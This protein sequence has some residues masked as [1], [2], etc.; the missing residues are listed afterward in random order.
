MTRLMHFESED[1][2]NPT[3]RGSRLR[4]SDPTKRRQ[5][6]GE[7]AKG[8]RLRLPLGDTPAETDATARVR[9]HISYLTRMAVEGVVSASLAR[10]A[11]AVW[12]VAQVSVGGSL[13]VPA[14]V[15]FS[16]GP[17]EYHWTVGSHQLS[18]EIPADGPCHWTYRNVKTCE[19][20]GVETEDDGPPP[21]LI[22]ALT[23]IAESSR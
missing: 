7:A 2:S 19:L 11:K 17:V 18:A 10:K 6:S 21:R 15:A 5:W 4:R 1:A 22:S 13:P 16:G 12:L 14:A 20:W 9:E 23:R 8:F 3:S